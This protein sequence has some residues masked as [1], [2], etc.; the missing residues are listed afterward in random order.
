MFVNVDVVFVVNSKIV[1]V[2]LLKLLTSF[3]LFRSHEAYIPHLYGDPLKI[4]FFK[5]EIL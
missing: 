2:H 3:I 4:Y 1:V 5:E